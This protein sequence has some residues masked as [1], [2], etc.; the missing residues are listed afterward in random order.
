MKTRN[1]ILAA[2]APLAAIGGVD[3]AMADEMAA[4]E[5]RVW[6][7]TLGEPDEEGMGASLEIVATA[8]TMGS[9]GMVI[10]SVTLIGTKTA[11]GED[12]TPMTEVTG[13]VVCSGPIMVEG[14]SFM[15]EAA[16]MDEEAAAM[17]EE[18]AEMA[19]SDD[20]AAMEPPCAFSISS[21]AKHTYRA[22]HSWDLTGM[23]TMGEAAMSFAI[24]DMA[25]AMVVEPEPE[26]EA[27]GSESS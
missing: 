11:A 24:E 17:D 7:A 26:A 15:L 18:K 19:K 14:G 16:A 23:V 12:G 4:P 13:S 21:D 2:L 5:M 22:W 25:P 27:E 3:A 1:F 20:D 9:N 8:S 6:S 10:E